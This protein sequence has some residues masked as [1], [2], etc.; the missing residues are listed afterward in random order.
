MN[1]SQIL[2]SDLSTLPSPVI[3]SL[4]S[5]PR[6]KLYPTCP[7]CGLIFAKEIDLRN[8][9]TE[10]QWAGYQEAKHKDCL[11]C[12]DCCLFFETAKGYM[13]H[14]GKVHVTKYKYSKCQ[15]C[16][17]K[18]R[19]KYAVKFHVKQVHEKATRENCP[20]CGKEFYNKY[21]LPGH[22]KKCRGGSE[23]N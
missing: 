12:K 8:H 14:H 7:H 10:E 22:M 20:T 17:K 4:I 6:K 23:D 3:V 1:Q 19:N 18:F 13:Q 9:L 2:M 5:F 15:V 16:D 11:H 21:L